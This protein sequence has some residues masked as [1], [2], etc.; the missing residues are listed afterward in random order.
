MCIGEFRGADCRKIRKEL[1][2]LQAIRRRDSRALDPRPTAAISTRKL[3][4]RDQTA[5]VEDP[6]V[7]AVIAMLEV[8]TEPVP[9]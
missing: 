5:H 8:C 7:E 9:F 4:L 6:A 3:V 2:A 1:A